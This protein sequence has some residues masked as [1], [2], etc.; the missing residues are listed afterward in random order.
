M[1]PWDFLREKF[2]FEEIMLQCGYFPHPKGRWDRNPTSQN[3]SIW[4][5]DR[6]YIHNHQQ[7]FPNGKQHINIGYLIFLVLYDGKLKNLIKDYPDFEVDS[8]Y[9]NNIIYC[10]YMSKSLYKTKKRKR[11]HDLLR[12]EVYG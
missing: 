4:V 11:I 10:T 12:K 6:N 1:T 2:S 3:P 5:R 7:D 8:D 9:N